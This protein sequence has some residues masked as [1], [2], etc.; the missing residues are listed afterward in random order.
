M[1]VDELYLQVAIGVALLVLA[2]HH[3]NVI[4][5]LKML[6]ISEKK[7]N[8]YDRFFGRQ[9][10]YY[11]KLNPTDKEKFIRRVYILLHRIRIEGR[12]GFKLGEQERLFVL[13]GYVQLTFGFKRF[14][15][16]K[17]GRIFVY[18]DAYRNHST[19]Q[20]H[21]GEV[22]PKGVIVLSWQKLLKGHQITD[23]SVNLGLHEMAHA[24]M[25]TI[26]HSDDHEEGLDPFLRDIVRYSKVE[27]ENI[28]NEDNHIFRKY[29]STNIY[30]FFSVAI[31]N[32]FENP[33]QLNDNL[34]QLYKYITLLLK[35]DPILQLG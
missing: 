17:F 26:I 5:F 20:M 15:M 21:Y 11:S 31:E 6:F 8:E 1:S 35:Q 2:I 9:F 32:F 34:P 29:A 12:Q 25:H 7:K 24:L 18:P 14:Y 23:D 10:E 13:A 22:N 30:E 19:G 27:M 16:P 4:P 33:K 28:K 3:F